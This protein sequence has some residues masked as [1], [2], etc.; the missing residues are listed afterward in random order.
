MATFIYQT[1]CG[2]SSLSAA[3]PFVSFRLDTETANV[4]SDLDS[5][6]EEILDWVWRLE[7]IWRLERRIQASWGDEPRAKQPPSKRA[8]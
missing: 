7:R 2:F 3:G 8:S 6:L 4:P 1:L 5:Q